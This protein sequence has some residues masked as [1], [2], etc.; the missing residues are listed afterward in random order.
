MTAVVKPTVSE[1]RQWYPEFSNLEKYPDSVLQARLTL[2]QCYVS[3]VNF[4]CLKDECRLQ[5]IYLMAAHL[6]LLNDKIASGQSQLGFTTSTSIDKV[7]VSVALPP[8]KNQLGYWLNTTPYGAQLL[9][10]LNS[11]AAIGLYYG[12]EYEDVFR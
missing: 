8:Y 6:Q 9:A 3:N 10:L 7:S 2:A 11:C 4:G 12:G 5:A 1:F